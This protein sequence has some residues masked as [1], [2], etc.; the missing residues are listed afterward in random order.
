MFVDDLALTMGYI[1]IY[2][3]MKIMTDI[4][5]IMGCNGICTTPLVMNGI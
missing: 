4:M 1:Y 2:M 5:I 3:Y